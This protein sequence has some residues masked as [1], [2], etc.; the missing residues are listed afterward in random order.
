MHGQWAAKEW[1]DGGCHC[2]MGIKN[3]ADLSG[4]DKKKA[5]PGGHRLNE[6]VINP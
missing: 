2:G 4:R 5:V 1:G 6:C 3:P